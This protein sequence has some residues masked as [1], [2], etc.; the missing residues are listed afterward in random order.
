MANTKK[1]SNEELWMQYYFEELEEAGIIKK[2]IY[3]PEP[4]ILS[5]KV[6]INIHKQLK[7]KVKNEV[8][9]LI[10]SHIY[11][12]DFYIEWSDK[13]KFHN[14]ISDDYFDKKP[15]WYSFMNKS[16]FEIK[17]NWDNNNMTRQF[18]TRTL[19]WVWEKYQIY[20]N[21]VKVPDIFKLTFIPKKILS[22]FY[23]K[24][25]T[26]KNKIGDKKYNWTY[27]SLEDYLNENN[28]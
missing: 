17:G 25:N 14:D 7:T 5:E 10:P 27:K 20:I 1:I 22:E 2:V 15:L 19:P 12:P 6:T 16:L 26:K 28:S 9:T 11:T 23:Y 21:L 3:Q 24:R 18:T 13:N 8:K 4:I